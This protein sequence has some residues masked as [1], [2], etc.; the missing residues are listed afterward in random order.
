MSVK[1]SMG[2]PNNSTT[3]ALAKASDMVKRMAA[4]TKKMAD[5]FIRAQKAANGL[6]GA[7]GGGFGVG[8]LTTSGTFTN[9]G[10][11]SMQ[12]MGTMGGLLGMT[13]AAGQF[14]LGVAGSAMN[15]M[16]TVQ[17]AVSMQLSLSQ[18][19]F[20]G[21]QGGAGAVR[22]A[23]LQGTMASPTDMMQAISMGNA[24]GLMPGMPGYTGLMNGVGQLS[25]ITGSATSAMNATLTMDS[26]RNVNR[27]R[28]FGI[29]VRN[30]DGGMRAPGAIFKDIAGLVERQTGNKLTA[31]GIAKSMQPGQGLYN[32]IKDLSGGDA[33]TFAA[34]QGSLMQF[35]KGG[36]LSRGST[37]QTGITTDAS[38]A[39]SDR[40]AANFRK[41]A[42]A[43]DPMAAGF[44]AATKSLTAV[45]NHIAKL[46]EQNSAVAG[47][48][49][50]AAG[51]ET[52]A[53]SSLGTAAMGIL[54]AVRTFVGSAGLGMGRGGAPMVGPMTQ[55]QA[56]QA[57]KFGMAGKLGVGA[58][59]LQGGNML[60][61]STLGKSQSER[62]NEIVGGVAG[63]GSMALTGA[64]IGT[65]IAP[66]IGTGVGAALGGLIGLGSNF[67]ALFGGSGNGYGADP[68]SS[69]GGQPNPQ[70]GLS[71]VA[72]AS[73]QL[74]VPYSWGGGSIGGPTRGI[75]QG[76]DTVGFDCSSLVVFVMSRL[77]ISMPRT[78]RE[79]QRVG[80]QINPK[81]A[82]PGDLLFWGQPAHH[83]AIYA[84][85]GMMIHAPSTGKNVERKAVNLNN[86]DSA[87]RVINAKTGAADMGNLLGGGSNP[88][89]GAGTSAGAFPAAIG[90]ALTPEALRGAS[91]E[92]AMGSPTSGG[93]GLGFGSDSGPD[94]RSASTAMA[95]INSSMVLSRTTGKLEQS[96]LGGTVV[97]YGGVTIPIT[98]KD[99]VSAKE[100]GKIIK[101]EL[102]KLQIDAKVVSS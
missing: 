94:N 20:F 101:E 85:N 42:A 74:G 3:G 34:L 69:S 80:Q 15:A 78:A 96:T 97:N 32:L 90:S 75:N 87:T 12:G 44:T 63:V 2:V 79:Q 9:L 81:D 70:A 82:Q 102:V 13:K 4:E 17:E 51:A 73:T 64:A 28:S 37:T 21:L 57:G 5:E 86:V 92:A 62:T 68:D 43:A 56:A 45:D 36:D 41:T 38:N 26:A 27:L 7:S 25:N 10:G 1:D 52:M 40:N 61:Q 55:A 14:G 72:V 95:S 50:L 31:A 83:V 23:M 48:L 46:I 93:S 22:G 53:A 67:G 16:P 76:S 84:G 47:A 24:G 29:N 49:K 89:G 77:G 99:A 100:V 60:Y 11:N 59:A 30:A 8:N 35:A 98:V 6:P 54:S 33:D 19:K 39:Q 18:A 88:L 65:M 66:G 58:I 91:A 71:A